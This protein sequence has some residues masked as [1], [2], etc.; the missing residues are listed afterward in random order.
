MTTPDQRPVWTLNTPFSTHI[1]DEQLSWFGGVAGG[2]ESVPLSQED[3]IWRLDFR[4]L[5]LYHT[6]ITSSDWAVGLQSS[7]SQILRSLS[8]LLLLAMVMLVSILRTTPGGS[9]VSSWF[10]DWLFPAHEPGSYCVSGSAPC[11]L[12]CFSASCY[13]G[14]RRPEW[15]RDGVGRAWW[16]TPLNP[17]LGRQRQADFWVR[18]QLGLQSEFQDSQGYTEK[19]CL[20]KLKKKSSRIIYRNCLDILVLL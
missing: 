16:C 12:T 2:G 19:L 17:A 11:V 10:Q 5:S 18:G 3:P 1:P 14:T 7:V 15:S 4:A 8:N 20:Q 6:V 13:T 9:D